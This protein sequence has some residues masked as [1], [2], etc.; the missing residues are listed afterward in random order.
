MLSLPSPKFISSFCDIQSGCILFEDTKCIFLAA[1]LSN[2]LAQI[3][4]KL[5]VPQ[6]EVGAYKYQLIVYRLDTLIE[7]TRLHANGQFQSHAVLFHP[8]RWHS[9]AS[10]ASLIRP[11]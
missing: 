1:S 5:A 11:H 6:G 8:L 10:L 7:A 9:R 3:Y 2:T 4:H